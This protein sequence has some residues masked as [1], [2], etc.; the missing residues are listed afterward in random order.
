MIFSV[1]NTAALPKWNDET[2]LWGKDF[3]FFGDGGYTDGGY[4]P[5]N[6]CT[7]IPQTTFTA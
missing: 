5:S 4:S 3:F 1:I 2:F 6:D 7:L